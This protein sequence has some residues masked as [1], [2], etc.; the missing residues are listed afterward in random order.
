MLN[1]EWLK[2]GNHVSYCDADRFIENFGKETGVSGLR[3]KLEAFVKNPVPEG[4]TYTGTRRTSIK[5]F[6]PDLMFDEHV[7]M[8]ENPW[9]FIGEMYPAY[10]IYGLAPFKTE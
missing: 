9:I 8:G 10:C 4:V 5:I 2:N 1:L 6:I 7:E 3:E